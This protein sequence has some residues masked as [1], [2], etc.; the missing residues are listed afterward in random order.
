MDV[1]T[2]AELCFKILIYPVIIIYMEDHKTGR[3]LQVG[4]HQWAT[5]E[6]KSNNQKELKKR[7]CGVI[8]FILKDCYTATTDN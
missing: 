4:T 3:E 2:V 5:G 7:N 6:K 8:W 1:Y